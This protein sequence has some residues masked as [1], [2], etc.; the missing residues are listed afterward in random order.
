VQPLSIRAAEELL[1]GLPV[2]PVISGSIAEM[3]VLRD[4]CLGAGIPALVGCPPGAGKG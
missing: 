2:V 4:R 1:E 3:K